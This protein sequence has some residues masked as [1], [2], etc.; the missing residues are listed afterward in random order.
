MS[1]YMNLEKLCQWAEKL[2]YGLIERLKETPGCQTG[3]K[4]DDTSMD[5][6]NIDIISWWLS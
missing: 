2:N 3:G 5:T 1:N 4:N 6:G